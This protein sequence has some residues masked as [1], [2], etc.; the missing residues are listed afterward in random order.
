VTDLNK[1]LNTVEDLHPDLVDRLEDGP[2]GPSISHPLLVD[3][4]ASPPMYAL[5]N[6]RYEHT[7]KMVAEAA[8]AGDWDRFIYFHARPYRLHAMLE[9]VA[10]GAKVDELIEEVWIDSEGPSANRDVWLGLFE[11]VTCPALAE[12]P[13]KFRIYRGTVPEDDDGISWTTDEKIAKFFA[14]RFKKGVVKTLEITR[15]SRRASLRR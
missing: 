9:A 14:N 5:L 8:G 4:M 15:D 11:S 1:L 12:L 2:L 13:D 3:L 6:E 7:K 10:I